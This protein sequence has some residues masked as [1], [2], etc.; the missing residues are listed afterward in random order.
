[1][2]M[3]GFDRSQI[4]SLSR[5]CWKFISVN[6]CLLGVVCGG[7]AIIRDRATGTGTLFTRRADRNERLLSSYE[8]SVYSFLVFLRVCLGR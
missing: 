4:V 1:M 2:A 7:S 3:R 6:E 8:G 5:R